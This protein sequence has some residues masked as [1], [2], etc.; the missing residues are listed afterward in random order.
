MIS[1]CIATY[2]GE[3]FI[4]EQLLSILNQLQKDDEVIISDD[5]STDNTLEIIRAI[6]DNRIFICSNPR[7]GVI[8]N[9]ENALQKSKGDFI[10]LADQ[11]DIWLPM[12]VEVCIQE[13]MQNDLI[14]SD[15]TVVDN[16]LNILNKSFFQLNNSK[17][18]KWEALMRNS[19]LG[20]CMAFKREVLNVA[21]PFPNKIPMHDIWIGNVAAFRFKVKFI[22]NSLIYYRRHGNNASTTSERTKAS[23]LKQIGYR[24]PLIGA[25]LSLYIKSSSNKF[26]ITT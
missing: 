25:L 3:A 1:V 16:Q 22:D 10:F 15:C 23:Y 6:N 19:Y 26:G 2:N 4:Q 5:N 9:I 24:L 12:K 8:S 21:L 14:V 18:N 20:C 11:D 13:L 7:K 17:K